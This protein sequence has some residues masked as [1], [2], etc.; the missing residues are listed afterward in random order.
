MCGV[1]GC[2]CGVCVVCSGG[3]EV[4]CGVCLVFVTLFT[5]LSLPL[6]S[7]C[8]WITEMCEY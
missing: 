3:A 1:V 5:M 4:W 2:V 7:P 8:L 6:L